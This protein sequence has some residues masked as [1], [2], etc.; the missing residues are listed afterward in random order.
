M[1]AYTLLIVYLDTTY[2]ILEHGAECCPAQV[3]PYHRFI[4]AISAA[5]VTFDGVLNKRLSESIQRLQLRVHAFM[6]YQS[7]G[8]ERVEW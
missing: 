4:H 2:V 8:D 3:F 7:S 5:V 6:Y 1:T